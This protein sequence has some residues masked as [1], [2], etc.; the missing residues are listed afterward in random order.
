MMTD[1]YRNSTIIRTKRGSNALRFHR[2]A[3]SSESAPTQQITANAAK[4]QIGA[5][6]LITISI[7]GSIF[8][9]DLQ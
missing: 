6:A 4:M 9:R 8:T 3:K 7:R 5:G 2:T 1:S